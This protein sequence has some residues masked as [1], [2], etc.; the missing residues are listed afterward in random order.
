M[1][2]P[3]NSGDL[4]IADKIAV[5]ESVRY[6][7]VSLYILYYIYILMCACCVRVCCVLCVCVYVLKNPRV[8]NALR[9]AIASDVRQVRRPTS[10]RPG[11]YSYG[12]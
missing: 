6:L 11:V 9:V 12:T 3:P 5:T 1:L 10:Q 2:L 4:Y 8:A 7:E